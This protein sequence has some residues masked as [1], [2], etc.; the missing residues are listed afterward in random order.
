MP[1]T[2]QARTVLTRKERTRMKRTILILAAAGCL[3]LALAD[4]VSAQAQTTPAAPA[5]T[6]AP[7][8]QPRAGVAPVGLPAPGGGGFIRAGSAGGGGA[9]I[10]AGGPARVPDGGFGMMGGFG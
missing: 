2:M 10:Y 9:T 7:P 1:I 3:P 5:A 6:P 8:G 4:G